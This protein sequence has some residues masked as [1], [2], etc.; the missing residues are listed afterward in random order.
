[1]RRITIFRAG[2]GVR[3]AAAVA[4]T[5]SGAAGIASAAAPP[6]GAAISASS[7]AAASAGPKAA[8]CDPVWIIGARGS[9]ES[10]GRYYGYSGMGAPVGYMASV[11]DTGLKAKDL[12]MAAIPVDYPAVSTNVLKPNAAVLSLLA[13]K[14]FAAA[15][16]EWAHTS[17]DRFDSSMNQGIKK[18]E[19]DVAAVVSKCPGSKIIMA[20]YS[21]GA[22]GIH[23]AE[24]Y[25]AEHQPAELTHIAGTLLLADPD[26]VSHSQAKEFGNAPV[27][28]EGVRTY[29][30]AFK[31][32]CVVRPHD[33]PQPATTASIVNAGDLVGDF[34]LDYLRNFAAHAKVHTSYTTKAGFRLLESAADWV[35]AKIPRARSSAV[36]Q[37][38]TVPL[39]SNA[40]SPSPGAGLQGV[41]CPTA[42]SCVAVG[43][44][45]DAAVSGDQGFILTRAGGPWS[46][47]Q[48]PLPAGAKF[49]SLYG[50][51]CATVSFCVAVGQYTDTSGS[52]YL[53]LLTFAAGS[54]SSQRAPLPADGSPGA[55]AGLEGVSCPSVSFCAAVGYYTDSSG[56]QDAL[57]L[58]LSSGTWSAMSAPL[59]EGTPSPASAGLYTVSC[60]TATFCA[61]GGEYGSAQQN[62]LLESW[63][64]KS[65]TAAQPFA[66]Y[67]GSVN[68]VSC[69]SASFCTLLGDYL[70][71]D[72]DGTWDYTPALLR[73]SGEAWTK[74][75]APIP[76]GAVEVA[77]GG[78]SCPSASFCAATSAVND[79][80]EY[81]EWSDML[82]T[83][84]DGAW[85]MRSSPVA[86]NLN[87]VSC[88]SA[89]NCVVVGG[90]PEGNPLLLSST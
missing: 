8:H 81:R 21:Q 86:P 58:K 31:Y 11:I 24:V 39:P 64:G 5:V 13:E 36:W 49:A 35:A 76:A 20:G 57:L 32:I 42:A 28:D 38:A 14:E 68:G 90:T 52:E 1:M 56:E 62:S 3:L 78:V 29:L 55:Y 30:C 22:V 88:S 83:W 2:R 89:W 54:W 66:G 37:T 40:A 75:P 41:S 33:V 23:D 84:S 72:G 85:A 44:Y 65:W 34:H 63:S 26:R 19:A 17:L 71:P 70:V 61:A 48:A 7:V 53:M 10:S 51:S 60:P 73:W 9:G 12:T 6:V 80:V 69:S 46:A 87:G 47:R 79:E 15:A 4:V 16:V 67:S 59:P 45:D 82:L 25:L 18:T 77:W 43:T 74:A 50:V 27:G